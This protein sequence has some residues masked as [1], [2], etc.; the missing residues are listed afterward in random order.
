MNKK[1]WFISRRA[2]LYHI[3]H[4]STIQPNTRMKPASKLK[5]EVG[6]YRRREF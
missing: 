1:L 5:K 3:E 4:S 6:H 2:L